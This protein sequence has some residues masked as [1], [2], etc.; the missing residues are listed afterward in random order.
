MPDGLILSPGLVLAGSR[1]WLDPS[2]S[3][4]A[5]LQAFW[6][7][8]E[9]QRQ[10]A[11]DIGPYRWNLTSATWP[12]RNVGARGRSTNFAG[13]SGQYLQNSAF[14][15]PGGKHAAISV[16]INVPGGYNG[17]PWDFGGGRTLPSGNAFYGHLPYGDNNAYFYYGN[18]GNGEIS[19]SLA[20]YLN[21]WIHIA[22]SSSP[23][24][25]AIWINGRL[26]NESGT[27]PASAVAAGTNAYVGYSPVPSLFHQGAM[28]LFRLRARA[29]T[30]AEVVRLYREPWAGT[31]SPAERLFF[32]VRAP[33]P[34][35]IDLIAESIATGAPTVGAPALGQIHGLTATGIA[36]GAPT[37]GTPALTQAHAL[38][39]SGVA[40]GAPTVGT[41]AVGQVH[42]LTAS[43]I[44][45]GAP[46]VG[47]P[48]LAQ[49]HA[50]VAVGIATG[51]PTVGTPG[52]NLSD[53]VAPA[54]RTITA[55]YVSRVVVAPYQSR[56]ISARYVARTIRV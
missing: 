49:V 34:T 14:R 52:L 46:T 20:S 24:R 44:A 23:T 21:Q 6:P 47:S 30:D 25:K 45:T 2:D 41:P 18:V 15:W 35:T 1:R 53:A 11:Y 5:D 42:A 3:I 9:T 31:T 10:T 38:A 13:A 26:A 8:D 27:V 43:S 32:P 28:R 48:A 37:V 19:T 55:R 16:W 22:W 12:T 4:N 51:A 29:W 33:A 40:T 56:T 7:L 54:E 17:S 36:I 50:L 39:A